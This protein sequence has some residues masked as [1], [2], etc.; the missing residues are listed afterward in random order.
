MSRRTSGQNGDVSVLCCNHPEVPRDPTTRPI[1]S[2]LGTTGWNQHVTPA[3]QN[4][5]ETEINLVVWS[6]RQYTCHVTLVL[7]N[8]RD[9]ETVK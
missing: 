1:R 7:T 3:I 6:R 4:M 8:Q 5:H 2:L 9:W